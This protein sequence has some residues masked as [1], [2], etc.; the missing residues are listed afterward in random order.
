MKP[1]EHCPDGCPMY[2]KPL[3]QLLDRLAVAVRRRKFRS[4][5][6]A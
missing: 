2:A 4:F 3:G 1:L 6:P 5:V